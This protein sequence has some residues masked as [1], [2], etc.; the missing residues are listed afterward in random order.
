M[1]ANA[2]VPNA[3]VAVNTINRP[4]LPTTK[5]SSIQTWIHDHSRM[6]IWT[7]ACAVG[8]IVSI[9]FASL[10]AILSCAIGFVLSYAVTLYR[11][12][13]ISQ[14]EDLTSNSQQET[15]P[16]STPA[17][18]SQHEKESTGNA[19]ET[20][21]ELAAPTLVATSSSEQSSTPVESQT[22]LPK[23]S[24]TVESQTDLPK[25]SSTVESQTDLLK[26]STTVEKQLE[27]AAPTSVATSSSEQSST[28]VESQP[29]PALPP[30]TQP[31]EDRPPTPIVPSSSSPKTHPSTP[32]LSKTQSFLNFESQ[33]PAA[34]LRNPTYPLLSRNF[35]HSLAILVLRAPT[36]GLI[37]YRTIHNGA[38]GKIPS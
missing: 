25:S 33:H 2:A 29:K 23:S 28:P 14:L 38:I 8:L 10:P 18:L 17:V 15:K 34:S 5:F 16:L 20:Q 22:D 6:R 12:K 3:V 13:K 21:P 7:I 35:I 24:S 36:I 37:A 31:L 26:S 9:I 27:P 11:E 19:V 30:R 4:P 1:S 32:L